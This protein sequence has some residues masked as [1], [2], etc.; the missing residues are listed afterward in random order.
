M[1]VFLSNYSRVSSHEQ[2]SV[3]QVSQCISPMHALGIQSFQQGEGT[4]GSRYGGL[5]A[6]VRGKQSTERIWFTFI[7]L[8]LPVTIAYILI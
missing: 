3:W 2:S 5:G 1:Q 8:C 4:I 6:E 7:H